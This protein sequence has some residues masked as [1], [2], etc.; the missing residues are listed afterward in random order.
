MQKQQLAKQKKGTIYTSSL[1][2][3][4]F[5]DDRKLYNAGTT[6]KV[7]TRANNIPPTITIP[8]GMRLLPAEPRDIAMGN[9]PRVVASVV[10]NIGRKRATEAFT[11]ADTS[12]SVRLVFSTN[13]SC[14]QTK[15]T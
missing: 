14:G 4:F 7:S 5:F 1:V 15:E 9:A 2:M 12:S 10:I 6:N 11:T 8:S 3:A 13:L